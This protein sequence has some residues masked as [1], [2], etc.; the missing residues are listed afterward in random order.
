MKKGLFLFF[1]FTFSYYIYGY[2]ECLNEAVITEEC[3]RELYQS[4]EYAQVVKHIDNVKFLNKTQRQQ[5]KIE[6]LL[7]LSKYDD[8]EKNINRLPSN[9]KDFLYY[10]LLVIKTAFARKR[11]TQAI[12]VMDMVKAQYPFY[13]AESDLECMKADIALYRKQYDESL[14][15]YDSCLKIK[16]GIISSYNRLLAME[17]GGVP[18]ASFLKDYI[19]YLET[20]SGSFLSPKVIERLVKLKE[21]SNS[22]K[23]NSPYY[24]RWL[25]I[26]HQSS[27]LDLFFNDDHLL[28]EYPSNMEIVKYLV[29]KN[30][31]SDALKM[32]DTAIE[33]NKDI[34]IKYILTVE[35]YRTLVLSGAER[36]A[37]DFMILAADQFSNT[38]KDRLQFFAGTIY[39]DAGF[40]E[41]GK[42]ILEDIVYNKPASK[43]FLLALYKLGL[44]FLNS[45]NELYAFTLWTN[46]IYD[47]SFNCSKYISGQ[48]IYDSI[49]GLIQTVDRLN[50]FCTFT[51][52]I[53]FD[54]ELENV[55][56]QNGESRFITYY[57]FLYF[58]LLDRE[59]FKNKI[60]LS[61]SEY[62]MKWK[63]NSVKIDVDAQTVLERLNCV[64][65]A[66]RAL[67]PV[68]MIQQFAA[69]YNMDGIEF[70]LNY[71]NS[72]LNFTDKKRAAS[73][74]VFPGK[75]VVEELIVRFAEFRYKTDV[76]FKHFF[77]RTGDVTD[78]YYNQ[79]NS[80]LTYSPHYGRKE[81][82]KLIYPTPFV[83][84]VLR[85]STEFGVPVQLIYSIMRA[86]TYYRDNLSSNAGALGLM[87][88][89]PA[90]FEKISKFGGIKIKDPF[91]PY[92][93]M[94][95]S[96][97]YLSKLLK[98]FDGNYV[99]AIAAYNAGPHRVSEWIT[100]YKGVDKY[101]FVEM[102]PFHE[103]RNYVKKVVRFFEIYSY[104]Y[105]GK[106]YD[107]GLKGVVNIEEIPDIVNF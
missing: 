50:G 88:V 3:V 11:F 24:S 83:D 6:A 9:I 102:I 42:K 16:P 59:E 36:D 2:Q 21:K 61:D 62:V 91:D 99:A 101:L 81:E 82:W 95:A 96:V 105:E 72:V 19:E 54:C 22:P 89:M 69:F 29:S 10:R 41:E 40:I 66:S 52:D 13:Y 51:T 5:I 103:T 7:K 107:M 46:Y 65:R 28:L 70:Y 71:M 38:K 80:E 8:V 39:F 33:K 20:Y 98:R 104:L 12:Q 23:S 37:A 44:I 68:V 31:F 47:S 78:Y 34:E 15:N 79:V 90:T 43:Y 58:H 32:L 84:D 93:S 30:R 26:M 64:S 85:L 92:D 100:R 55:C 106:F 86:E 27:K 74:I 56:Q 45:G 49:T 63:W 76:V 77:K 94:K 60:D 4:G 35:K 75:E 67:E 17:K 97:W 48:K 14:S 1:I 73:A 25:A 53:D 18:K 87:Q 57:D